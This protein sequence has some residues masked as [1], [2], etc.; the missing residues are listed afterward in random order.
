MRSRLASRLAWSLC[1]A[2]LVL[3]ALALLLILLGWSTELPKGWTPW[4][5]QVIGVLG[6]FGAP[7]LGGLIASRHP[8]NPYG[9]LW[10]GFG[11]GFA[12]VSLGEPYAAYALVVDPGSLPAPR[13][14]V[15]VLGIA[16]V[17]FIFFSPFL[18]LLFPDGR[19]P[20]RRWRFLVWT[21][22]AAGA[23][24]LVL[25]LFLPGRSGFAP[26]ENPF[27]IGGTFGDVVTVLVNTGVFVIFGAIVISALS[28]VFRFRRTTGIERQQIKWFAY[29]A[30]V[31]GGSVAFSGLLGF[32]LPGVWDALFEAL[33]FVG[34]YVAVGIAILKYRLYEIDRIINRTLVYGALTLMLA[35][36]YFG[37]VTLLQATFR[38][39][40]GQEQQPQF[41]IVAS[42]LVIAA[43]FNPLRRRIQNFIDRRFYRGKYDAKNTL[44]AFSQKLRDETDL[45][46]LGEDLVAVVRDTMQPEHVSI[47]LKPTRTT[48]KERE[49]RGV[50][51]A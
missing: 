2:S 12:L 41:V 1:A 50:A 46:V 21:V 20:S 44:Q 3:V 34:L 5:D 42:T 23:M 51:R 11:M 17:L 7:I 24:L 43:L 25:A 35:A 27:G 39:L 15:Q 48:E 26:V 18:L 29:A 14:V 8:R 28:L 13:T 33:T 19:L 36:V 40:T 45:D 9:W 38:V 31:L 49:D 10:L 32:E 6:L 30:V 47:W 16:W 4:R 37:G 22:A